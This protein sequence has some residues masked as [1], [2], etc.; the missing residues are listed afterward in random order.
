MR[1]DPQCS[2]GE[3]FGEKLK[4][5]PSYEENKRYV[6]ENNQR[7]MVESG[8]LKGGGKVDWCLGTWN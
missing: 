5:E 4:L 7:V 1:T 8:G 6:E 2:L 3:K